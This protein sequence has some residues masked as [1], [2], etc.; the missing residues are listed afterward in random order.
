VIALQ[1]MAGRGTLLFAKMSRLAV[2]FNLLPVQCGTRDSF[3]EGKTAE[4]LASTPP[5]VFMTWSFKHRGNFL[6]LR[7][8]YQRWSHV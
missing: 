2:G 6:Y 8:L 5:Y 4:S 1:S 7:A 3:P